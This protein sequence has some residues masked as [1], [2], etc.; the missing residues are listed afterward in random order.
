MD[1]DASMIPAHLPIQV[2]P[3][4]SS[5]EED[6]ARL[7][8]PGDVGEGKTYAVLVPELQKQVGSLAVLVETA[9]TLIAATGTFTPL[10]S[11]ARGHNDHGWEYALVI[12]SLETDGKALLAQATGMKKGD[13]EGIVLVLADTAETME[14]YSEPLRTL[15]QGVGASSTAPP[16]GPDVD[17]RYRVPAGWTAT[18]IESGVLLERSK[19]EEYQKYLFRI[20][21][22]PSEP[23]HDSLKKT[24][25]AKWAEF[26]KPVFETELTPLPLMHRLKSGTAIAYDMDSRAKTQNG[27][28]VN[29]GLYLLARGKRVAPI[30]VV[31]FGSE[32]GSDRLEADITALLES[33]EIPGAGSEKTAIYSPDDLLGEWSRSSASL[34]SYV[35]ASGAYAGDASIAT[36]AS[37]VLNADRSFS[38]AFTGLSSSTTIQQN[39]SGTW[40]LEDTLLVLTGQER[41]EK[42][43]LG[44]G[45]DPRLGAF[46]VLS[47]GEIAMKQRYSDPRGDF[48]GEWF[49]R[50]A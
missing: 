30:G 9:E 20:V 35:T 17:L 36:A 42:W 10:S 21:I 45:E 3:G 15:L 25:L 49:K 24:Y 8:A 31:L 43:V 14:R 44:V 39:D 13:E 37:L 48:Q 26:T 4:W 2:P 12:G 7:L 28:G 11:P 27:Q 50:K 32:L 46:L 33:A 6:G 19:N 40:K 47:H 41:K 16:P 38:R 18:R 22:L 34:A 29:A 1:L 23:L 5:R